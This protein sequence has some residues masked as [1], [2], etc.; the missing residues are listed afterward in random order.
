VLVAKGV[1]D[2]QLLD[3]YE[4]ER[5]P[6]AREVVAGTT[7]A[8]RTLLGGSAANNWIRDRLVLPVTNL[9]IVQSRLRSVAGQLSV[10]YRGGPLALK[11]QFPN[12]LRVGDRVADI[13]CRRHDG[14]ATRLHHELAGR[15]ALVAGSR[16]AL[17]VIDRLGEEVSVL[18]APVTDTLL[19]RLD[20]HLA[21]QKRQARI[22]LSTWLD[23]IFG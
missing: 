2:E 3:T 14:T 22:P 17:P 12:G 20:A 4:A 16:D 9:P 6:V 13:A 19:I 5:R 18:T 11:F 21:W 23:R 1:A 8:T 10:S 15:W 7:V